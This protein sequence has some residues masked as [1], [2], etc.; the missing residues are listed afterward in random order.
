MSHTRH[1]CED[2]TG[3]YLRGG[4]TFYPNSRSQER[5]LEELIPKMK[6]VG[7]S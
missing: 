4:C 6:E 3:A 1:Y 5:I 2:R 7:V